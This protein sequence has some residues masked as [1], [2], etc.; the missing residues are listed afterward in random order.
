MALKSKPLKEVRPSLPLAEV[1]KEELV[2]VNLNVSKKTRKEWKAAALRHDL[3]LTDLI[4]RAMN[5]Y[6][7]KTN[8]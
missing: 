6:E 1:A 3:T 8:S 7:A 2:R 4:I 5:A